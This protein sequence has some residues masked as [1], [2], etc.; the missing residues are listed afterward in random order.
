MQA[1]GVQLDLRDIAKDRLTAEEF[2]KLIGDRDYK[3]FLNSR[4]EL[5]RERNMKE[6]PPSCAEALKLMVQEPNLIRR[7]LV[8]RGS[9]IVVGYDEEALKKIAKS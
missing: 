4:N 7:P 8:I 9:Q 3:L 1:T 2:D 6:Y 5:Y